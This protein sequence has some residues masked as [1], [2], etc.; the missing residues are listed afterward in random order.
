L[1][2]TEIARSVGGEGKTA[3]DIYLFYEKGSEW[4]ELPP[5]PIAWMH[6]LWDRW[7]DPKHRHCGEELVEELRKTMRVLASHVD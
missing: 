1:V 3:W 2:G 5:E 7:A 4:D 6:Q